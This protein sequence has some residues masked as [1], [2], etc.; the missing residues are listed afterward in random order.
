M[1]PPQQTIS[2]AQL[3]AKAESEQV[4]EKHRIA[5]FEQVIMMLHSKKCF[6]SRQIAA[7]LLQNANVKFSHTI[8]YN[9]IKKNK[10]A[11]L[12]EDDTKKLN[13]SKVGGKRKAKK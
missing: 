1:T 11:E 7:W 13:P 12:N 9:C 10:V 5:E 4:A 8:I 3:M 2:I 6:T